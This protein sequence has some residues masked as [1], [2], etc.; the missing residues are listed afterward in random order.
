MCKKGFDILGYK[1]E[2]GVMVGYITKIDLIVD[3]FNKK[4]MY[5][6]PGSVI[7]NDTRIVDILRLI[8][9]K[10][11]LFVLENDQVSGIIT[12]GDLQKAPVRLLFFGLLTLF[13]MNIQKLIEI[14]YSDGSW[15]EFVI[16]PRL[17]GAKGR[18]RKKKEMNADIGL[19]ECLYL[20]DKCDIVTS[21]REIWEIFSKEFDIDKPDK[22]Y[23]IKDLRDKI[24]HP[25]D[26]ARGS[27]WTNA[28]QLM[29]EVSIICEKM[30]KYYLTRA[31]SF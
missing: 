10:E 8:Q 11:R 1:N 30:E 17:N 26:I 27:D 14:F 25:Q 31:H 19:L 16:A 21:G 15:E 12:R 7:S 18:H 2:Q 9:N 28:I 22:L 13:E 4:P 23:K 20:K 3:K 24:D 6:E 29:L 5:F